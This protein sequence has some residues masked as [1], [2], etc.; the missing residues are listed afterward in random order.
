MSEDKG[1]PKQ[2]SVPS[3]ESQSGSGTASLEKEKLSLEIRKLEGD[4]K[5]AVNEQQKLSLEIQQLKDQLS[6]LGKVLSYIWPILSS[7]LTVGVS[8]LAVYISVRTANNQSIF[9]ENQQ[10]DQ[11]LSKAVELATDSSGFADRRIAGIWELNTFWDGKKDDTILAS[12]LSA[13]LTL[14]DERRFARCAAAEVVGNAIKTSVFSDGSQDVDTAKKRVHLLY[15]SRS[16]DIGIV[17]Q[18]H[19]MLR[20]NISSELDQHGC[21]KVVDPAA[22]NSCT[23]SLDATREA[24]RKNWAYLRDGNFNC[25]DLSKIQLYEAD[26]AGASLRGAALPNANFRCANLYRADMTGADWTKADFRFA[27]VSEAVPQE[28]VIFAKQQGAFTKMDDGTWLRWRQNGFLVKGSDYSLDA[29]G[30]RCGY[31]E[32]RQ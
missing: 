14:G 23:T 10:H 3:S 15:G 1:H 31:A 29:S 27:N 8:F 13:E 4:L 11:T 30:S 5:G 24:I 28:F 25:T 6:P 2:T 22:S 16:G 20:Q 21:F 9:Q 32:A 7:I 19:L 18:Q 26:L 12:V 17:I